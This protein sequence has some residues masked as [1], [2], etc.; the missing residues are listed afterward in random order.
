VAA[1]VMYPEVF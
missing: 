1:L